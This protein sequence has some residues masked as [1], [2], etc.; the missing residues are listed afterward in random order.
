ME[1]VEANMEIYEPNA[2]KTHLDV[3][4]CDIYPNF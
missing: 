2:G 4:K 1:K 3:G